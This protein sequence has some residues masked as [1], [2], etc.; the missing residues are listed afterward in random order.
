MSLQLNGYSIES[1]LLCEQIRQEIQ[2]KVSIV[3]VFSSNIVVGQFPSTFPITIYLEID[4]EV[5]GEIELNVKLISPGSNRVEVKIMGEIALPGRSY[6]PMPAMPLVCD[7]PGPVTVEVSDGGEVWHTLI[8][9][10]IQL[11]DI[12]GKTAVN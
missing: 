5:A 4:A 12:D 10:E 6:I 11:G 1:A 8:A 3:G 7:E 9:R 2:N